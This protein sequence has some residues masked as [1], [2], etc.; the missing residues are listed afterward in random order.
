M[1]QPTINLEI[2][3]GTAGLSMQVK[4]ATKLNHWLLTSHQ[5][6][7]DIFTPKERFPFLREGDSVTVF[8][9][10]VRAGLNDPAPVPSGLILPDKKLML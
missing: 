6:G 4:T 8:I 3:A 10:L 5:G 2:K 7:I 9:N 1:T